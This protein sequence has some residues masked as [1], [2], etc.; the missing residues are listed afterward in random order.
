MRFVVKWPTRMQG[1][2]FFEVG[3]GGQHVAFKL[4]NKIGGLPNPDLTSRK[5]VRGC[6][7]KKWVK[8]NQ[9]NSDG[10]ATHDAPT[11]FI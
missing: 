4:K 8:N 5:F 7:P 6:P 1:E 11:Y 2:I 10:L 9:T 3:R